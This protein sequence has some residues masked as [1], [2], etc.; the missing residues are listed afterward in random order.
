MFTRLDRY[1]LRQ[2][3]VALV[4]VTTALVAL[5]WLTQSLRLV[6]LVVNHG[7]SFRVF[8]Q[9]TSLL[10]PG[11]VAVILPITTFVVV[12]F[13]YQRLSGDRELTVMR[14]AG[15]SNW[16]L[17]RPAIVLGCISMAAGL[18]LNLWVVPDSSAAFRRYEFEIR[19]KVAAFL[20]QEGVFTA[21]SDQL[22][23]YVRSRDHDGTLRG[24]LVEDDRQANTRATILAERGR[25][26][27][28]SGAPRVL[29][30][31][32]SREEIDRKTGR[33]DVL[34]FAEDTID[35]ATNS[36]NDETRMRE[37]SEMSMHELLNPD[38][39]EVLERDYG[40]LAV[41]AHHRLTQPITALAFALVALASVLTGSFQRYGNL[42]R[43]AAAVGLL[44]GLLAA[45][46]AVASI[47]TRNMAMI[48]LIWIEAALPGVI[49][50]WILFVPTAAERA[51][52]RLPGQSGASQ[53]DAAK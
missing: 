28:T 4:A 13:I 23:V 48:P 7:L 46:L 22:T 9:L 42:A 29:L 24:I 35:L 15:L 27:S 45:A 2:L 51:W 12:Q 21:I 49:A 37:V 39:T 11:F 53:P 31:N 43:P 52:T 17:S 36:K 33:L 47:A 26:I 10:I 50:A 5:I 20:L 25:L 16:A 19:N 8:L 34:T 38:P 14:A 1:I 30:Q 40:K 44:V 32:G 41:E 6:E 18:V 3:L